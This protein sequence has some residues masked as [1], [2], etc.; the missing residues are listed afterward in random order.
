M[1][2]HPFRNRAPKA[3]RNRALTTDK[4]VHSEKKNFAT[5]LVDFGFAPL[6]VVGR[7]MQFFGVGVVAAFILGAAC[8]YGYS[9]F[10]IV[11]GTKAAIAPFVQP[12]SIPTPTPAKTVVLHGT[13]KSHETQFEIGVLAIRRG[14]FEP[15][16]SYSIEVPESDRYLVV[17]WYPDY[18]KFKMQDM[19][20]DKTGTLQELVFPTTGL[21]RRE[22][23][24][25][26]QRNGA[27][28]NN[29]LA[30]NR[31][32]RARDGGVSMRSAFLGGSK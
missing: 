1:Q 27:S 13:V 8:L 6:A 5:F 10:R 14:P 19:S 26:T 17:G 3:G 24:A 7:C 28:G 15:N 18:S 11:P 21:A 32:S 20:P 25:D 12:P 31:K 23:P 16:G 22:G 9:V 4:A 30:E 29:A 2:N